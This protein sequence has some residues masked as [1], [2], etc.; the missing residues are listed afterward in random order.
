MRKISAH[1]IINPGEKPIR[2]G[3]LEVDEDGTILALRSHD[4]TQEESRLEFYNG[5]LV[6]GFVNVH[7]HLELSGMKGSI[8]K[9]TGISGFIDH[10]VKIRKNI[11]PNDHLIKK[12]MDLMYLSGVQFAGDICNTT[13]TLE[14][15][16][17]HHLQTH[18]FIELFG[19]PSD[20]ADSVWNQGLEL[21]ENFI[22]HGLSASL[23]PHAP[24]SV[25]EKLWKYFNKNPSWCDPLS[26]HHMESPEEQELFIHHRGALF[27][28]ISGLLTN[29]KDL[30]GPAPSSTAWI[31]GRLPG[32]NSSLLI[33]N[34]FADYAEINRMMEAH[35]NTH[36]YFGMCPNANQYIEN[37][38]PDTVIQHRKNLRL[39]F[40][41]DSLASNHHLSIW[42]EIKT[43][44]AAYP[45][46]Q[47][48]EWIQ[49]AC[50]NGAMVFGLEDQIGSFLPGKKP[51]IILLEKLSLNPLKIKKESLSRRIV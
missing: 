29:L 42:E 38:L 5:V 21:R 26:I 51:G 14:A 25:S 24:Y 7:T 32:T 15:K 9:N 17:N 40:G 46:I 50:F 11:S 13:D 1:Y 6:P 18:S 39:C 28:R 22:Q 20:L 37:A 44:A 31:A 43:L 8:P 35:P 34:T 12:Q 2:D 10:V 36:F 49:M 33:H 27:D 4:P 3:V 30:P 23:T 48:E 16:K 45:E 47:L 41:T 19:L